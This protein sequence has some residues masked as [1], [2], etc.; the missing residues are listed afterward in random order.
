MIEIIGTEL[1]QWDVSRSVKVTDVGATHVHFANTGDSKAVIMEIA[2]SVALIPD[3]LLQTGKQ[4]C[5]YAVANGVTIERKTFPVR[6]RERPE[7]YVYDEDQRN[8]IY[9]IIEDAESAT[10]E[11]L[12]VA[13]ELLTARDNGEFDGPKGAILYKEQSLTD[14]Q[15]AQAR[16]NISA[17]SQSDL[18]VERARINNLASLPSG[19]TMADAELMDIRVAYNGN[20]YPSA[21]EAVR[22][23][24]KSLVNG[25]FDFEYSPN[26]LNL[27]AIKYNALILDTNGVLYEGASYAA[28]CTT[29]YIPCKAGDTIRHQFTYTSD[30]KA[31]RYDNTEKPGYTNMARICGYDASG[32]FVGG[33]GTAY[34]TSYS[35][36]NGVAFVRISFTVS[37]F[38]N[39]GFSDEAII[40]QDDATVLP[41]TEYGAIVS[42]K[43]NP[44]IAQSAPKPLAFLPD[45]ICVAVGRTIE[46]YNN[47][48][49]PL[50]E[51]YHFRWVCNVGKALKRKFSITGTGSL[52]GNYSLALEIYDDQEELVYSKTST[53]KIVAG[54][55][56]SNVSICTIGDSLTN[57]KYWMN[58]VQALSSNKVSFV[59][60]RGT[61]AGRKHEGRSGFTSASYL[62]ATAYSYENEGVHPF[63]DGSKF[64]WSYYKTN[65]G[66]NPSA[67][68]IFLG[69]NDLFSNATPEAFSNNI[70]TMVD[71]IRGNDANIPIFVVMTILPGNQNG[72][73][74]QQSSDGF[75]SQKGKYKFGLDCRYVESM[76]MLQ[77]KL[78]SYTNLH[79]VPLAECHDNEYNFGS[80]ETPVNPRASQKE[81]MPTEGVHPQQQGYEQM[82]DI[83]YSVY[84]RAYNS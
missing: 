28:Y 35:V 76:Q 1:N 32:N 12:R 20:K 16:A 38:N 33:S 27:G 44:E 3:Y 37:N 82:A 26:L 53:L 2:D 79:F 59:G 13:D 47:Q 80:V 66:I 58:E 57:G 14:G 39:G 8:Y 69:T 29:D 43:L 70:K 21:G 52:V 7:Y 62:S 23:Q 78:N 10:D 81:L 11:A 49:C 65:T 84:C 83:M 68:Q 25:L 77:D 4:L 42:Q 54:S 73:G 40:I 72:I 31:T 48:V 36:P 30:G 18:D 45:E 5:V 74:V 71:S 9:K 51:K 56:S 46:I 6:K 17:A 50:A 61:V 60:T 67:V 41:F 24:I 34:A 22:G 63:W 19:S 64:S 55:L 15:K 75:A